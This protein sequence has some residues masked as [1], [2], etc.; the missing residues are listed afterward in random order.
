MK[1]LYLLLTLVLV[2]SC[3]PILVTYD[4]EKT[5][6]FKDYKTYN[7]YSDI[8]SGMSE[9]E[10]KRLFNILDAAL[11]SRGYALTETPDFFIDIKSTEFQDQ[12]G[13]NVAV[14]LGG[15]G[16]N[17]GGGI[18]VGLPLGQSQLSREIVFEFVDENGLGLFWQAVS[19]ANYNPNWSPEKREAHFRALVE[20]VL[21]GFPP[22][23]N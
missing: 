8:N 18:S 5:A 9:L 11:Q 20:K 7:Y 21:E 22:E 1:R 10:T 14:G 19:E 6:N 12:R 15:T 17:V 3:A 23:V 13:N 16:R 2:T 4:Y